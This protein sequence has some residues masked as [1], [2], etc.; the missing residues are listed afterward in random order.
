MDEVTEKQSII[1]RDIKDPKVLELDCPAIIT[2]ASIFYRA[3]EL[4]IKNRITKS[5]KTTYAFT[6]YIKCGVC[7]RSYTGYKSSK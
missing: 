2:D 1:R 7:G 6:G 5:N 3:Q 4:L